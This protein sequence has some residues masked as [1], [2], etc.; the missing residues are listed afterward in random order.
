MRLS[1]AILAASL[2]SFA[3]AVTLPNDQHKNPNTWTSAG[4]KDRRQTPKIT[5]WDPPKELVAP[6]DEA[7][8]RLSHL[9]EHETFHPEVYS[10]WGHDIII[11]ANGKLR[12]CIRW[13]SNDVLSG[14]ARWVIQRSLTENV[15][16]WMA[17]MKD[18]MGWPYGDI[19]IEL[20][21]YAVRD[22]SLVEGVDEL[23]FVYTAGDKDGI[24]ECDPRCGRFFHRDGDYSECPGG[25]KAI[26][27]MSLWLTKGFQGG[28]GGDWGQRLNSDYF[29]S[30]P[31]SVIFLQEFGHTLG[32]EDFQGWTSPNAPS[33][34]MKGVTVRSLTDFDI[35]I[36]RNYWRHIRDARYPEYK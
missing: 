5:T 31:D 17:F 7:W 3:F 29:I 32:I 11:A 36:M 28:Q 1:T 35:W 4:K 30:T 10:N 25:E 26:Y 27:D 2:Q 33:F 13:E 21:G 16:K 15:N 12:Y 20:A 22:R 6:L 8:D 9:P 14:W 18:F 23:P 19:P 24:P 34:L